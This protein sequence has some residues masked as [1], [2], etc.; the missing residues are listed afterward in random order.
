MMNT[1]ARSL[2]ATH[3]VALPYHKQG[4]LDRD[5]RPGRLD[6]NAFSHTNSLMFQP[7]AHPI[8]APM[9]PGPP[10]EVVHPNTRF[11]APAKAAG[12]LDAPAGI[13]VTA[14]NG[15]PLGGASA[16]RGAADVLRGFD[17]V[18]TPVILPGEGAA[19]SPLIT[20]GKILS[21]P[22]RLPEAEFGYVS[23]L[24]PTSYEFKVP[25]LPPKDAKLHQLASDAGKRLR[26]RTPGRPLPGGSTSSIGS[27]EPRAD[28]GRMAGGT[29]A[30]PRLSDAAKRMATALAGAGSREGS[31]FGEGL[32]VSYAPGSPKQVRTP[33]LSS[34]HRSTPGQ[35]PKVCPAPSPNPPHPNYLLRAHALRIPRVS[36]PR[37]W[38]VD[39]ARLGSRVCQALA[40][41]GDVPLAECSVVATPPVCRARQGAR[42]PQPPGARFARRRSCCNRVPHPCQARRL[43]AVRRV[44]LLAA[45]AEL[46]RLQMGCCR[47]DC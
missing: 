13:A 20:W 19:E 7:D 4:S 21:S 27:R 1:N 31:P 3:A 5:E 15:V 44:R 8:Q 33:R 41:A 14:A 45:R 6:F 34:S 24:Q 30:S 25:K 2:R 39:S 11:P 38:W 9:E 29:A 35:A 23:R 12:L 47:S 40:H 37:V 26:A 42:R 36:T 28:A 18:S 17:L 43:A 16:G 22:L 10:P 32:R 46:L